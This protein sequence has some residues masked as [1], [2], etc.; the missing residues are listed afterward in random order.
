MIEI[1]DVW[2]RLGGFWVLRGVNMRVNSVVTLVGPNGSGKTTLVKIIA[3]VLEPS[4]GEV[5][6]DGRRPR[7]PASVL[8]VVFHTP[9]LYPELTVRENLKLFA[10][11]SGGR[12]VG[13]PLG[14]CKVLDKP[15]KALS[16]G[17]RRRVDVVRALL[18]DPPNLVIDEPT[19]GLDE[20]A[21][22]ELLDLL[23][24]RGA[25]LLTSPFPLGIGH[26]VRIEDVQY[27]GGS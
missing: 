16:F 6:V 4:R 12:L 19:T 26:E 27:A 3:G 1:R 15:V 22:G 8:G 9:M 21:R 2:K 11:L 20:E 24:E 7:V 23:K 25:A 14:V 18:P 13:C 5:L 10:K 17:W